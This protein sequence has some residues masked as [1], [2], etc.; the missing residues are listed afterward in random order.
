MLRVCYK[1][2]KFTDPFVTVS[3]HIKFLF[4]QRFSTKKRR[5]EMKE[6]NEK[7]VLTRV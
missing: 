7:G 1:L 3:S 2:N 6:K 5:E 4:L